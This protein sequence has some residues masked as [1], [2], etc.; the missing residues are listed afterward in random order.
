MILDAQFATTEFVVDQRKKKGGGYIKLSYDHLVE[1]NY[2][3]P[4]ERSECIG[5]NYVTILA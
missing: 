1:T 4:H 5:Y 3:Q 2:S